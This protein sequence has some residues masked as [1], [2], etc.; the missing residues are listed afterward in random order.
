M[1]A[2]HPG[3]LDLISRSSHENRE[4]VVTIFVNP[5]QFGNQ[6]DLARYPRDL[7]PDIRLAGSAGATLIFA[8]D[9][10]EIYP[11]GFDT[12]VVA[13]TLSARWEGES[14]PGHFR[15]VCT[16]VSI[17]LNL[18]RP[19]RSY[20]GEKDFQQLQ[21]IRRMHADLALPGEIVGCETVRDEDGLAFSSRNAMLDESA[22]I[23]ALAIPRAIHVVR[24]AAA[25][26]ERNASRL[27]RM[28]IGALS[29]PGI[30]IDYLALVDPATLDPL[31]LLEREAILLIAAEI[32]GIRLIDNAAIVPANELGDSR[33]TVA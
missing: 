22:R 3:H 23:R 7:T 9:V 27:E 5:A 28:G 6:R 12:W 13:E 10:E 2:L 29:G 4:T 8:P 32:G 20:F 15:G 18:V 24:Q 19:A 33:T 16:I 30:S 26:G 17:L 25:A 14:R 31:S 1:G 11:T 21:I